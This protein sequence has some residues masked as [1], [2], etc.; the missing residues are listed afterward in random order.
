MDIT[1]ALAAESQ[2][3][4]PF[5]PFDANSSATDCTASVGTQIDLSGLDRIIN[6]DQFGF[7]V[8]VQPGVRIGD[9]AQELAEYELES[10]RED[11]T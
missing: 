1:N 6:I 5:R 8:T 4:P 2:F 9:L 10:F 11:M 7:T 3:S